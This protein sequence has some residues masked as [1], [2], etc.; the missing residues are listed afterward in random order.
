MHGGFSSVLALDAPPDRDGWPLTLSAPG[1]GRV[2]ARVSVHRRAFSASGV[3]KGEHIVDPRT[4]RPV[5][6]RAAWASVPASF[7]AGGLPAAVAEGFS[8]AFM[9]L[10]AEEVA[11]LC[12]GCSGLEAWLVGE[13]AGEA[14][15]H[16]GDPGT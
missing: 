4:G 15:L 14:L 16:L 2:L 10:S 6:D 9:I 1:D 8:T 13:P 5:R 7:E 11:D 3:R 12:R